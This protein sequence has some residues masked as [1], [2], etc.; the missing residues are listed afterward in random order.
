M[1]D[2]ARKP[3]VAKK[4]APKPGTPKPGSSKPSAPM[5]GGCGGAP[6]SKPT[7]PQAGPK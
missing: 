5:G 3:E 7:N 6:A 2:Q 1:A 4:P